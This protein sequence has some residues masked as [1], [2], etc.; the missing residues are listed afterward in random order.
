M[1]TPKALV[2]GNWK[3]NGVAANLAEI[4]KLNDLIAGGGANCDVLICPPFT[5]IHQSVQAAGERVEI[6]GQDCHANISGAHTGDVSAAMIKDQG[7][8]YVIVGHSERRTDHGETDEMVSS[9]ADAAQK[10]ELVAIICVGETE[11]ERD[12]GDA[13]S[14]VTSQVR[15]S[16]PADATA[17]NTVIAYEPVWAIGT[18]RTPTADD[19]AEV[20]AAIRNVLTE[21]F[22]DAGNSVRI[23]YGGSVKPENARELMSVANV[24]GALVGG[25]SLKADSFYGIVQAYD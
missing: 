14:V 21:R 12:A 15:G 23:L 2:A 13:L 7:C 20:H 18:G 6:G 3:M 10:E 4:E 17:D 11:A 8:S 1:T 19:V 24:N 16:I 25:A 9:K 5:L 22:G